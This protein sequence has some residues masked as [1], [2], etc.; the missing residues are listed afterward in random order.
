MSFCIELI[1]N[2]KGQATLEA[3]FLIPIVFVLLL[4]LIQPGILLYNRMVMQAAASEGCRLLATKTDVAGSSDEKCEAY[5]LRR[6][7]S[8]PP[9]ENFHIHDGGCAWEIEMVGNESSLEVEVTIKNKAKLLPLLDR[10][11]RLIGISDSSGQYAQ[12]VT[13]RMPTQP[14]WVV[15]SKLGLN[16]QGWVQENE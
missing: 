8:I 1:R 11:A 6:L 9:Q 14:S 2:Q 3:A 13:V 15:G 5:I 12:E 16:P 7:G 10:G 4:L